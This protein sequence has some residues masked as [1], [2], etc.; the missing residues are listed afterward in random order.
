MNNELIIS[1]NKLLSRIDN[2]LE[3]YIIDSNELTQVSKLV[4]NNV[5]LKKLKKMIEYVTLDLTSIGEPT[6]YAD[7]K[8]IAWDNQKRLEIIHQ[9]FKVYNLLEMDFKNVKKN[10]N[11]CIENDDYLISFL[12]RVQELCKLGEKYEEVKRKEVT[13]TI[14]FYQMLEEINNPQLNKGI[15][16]LGD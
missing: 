8:D 1:N 2:L 4:V 15:E 16:L 11:D 9:L 6:W 10:K 5:K 14:E 13:D 3:N 12:G 7:A